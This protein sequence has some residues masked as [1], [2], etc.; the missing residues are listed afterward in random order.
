VGYVGAEE[1]RDLEGQAV[2]PDSDISRLRDLL[3]IASRCEVSLE[4]VASPEQAR[5]RLGA[6]EWDVA[7]LPPGLAAL[8]ME[9]ADQRGYSLL[10]PLGQRSQSRSQLLVPSGSHRRTLAQLNGARLGLL[11]RGS[12]TGFYLPLYNLHGLRLQSVHYALSY[13]ELLDQLR[14][15]KLDVIAWDASLPD[16]GADVR[17]IVDDPNLIPVGALVLSQPLVAADHQPFLNLLDQSAAQLPPSLG[18]VAGVLPEAQGLQRLRTVVTNVESWT[19]P[20][21]GRP[22]A[23]YGRKQQLNAEGAS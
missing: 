6:G 20:L 5:Q 14:A 9:G 2:L 15:G 3:T 4:P 16:P 8:A 17:V 13:S 22:Y 18:Y 23:V 21:K 10:R 11:P 12:L 19:L 1:G 7:F